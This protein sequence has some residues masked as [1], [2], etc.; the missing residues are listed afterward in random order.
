MYALFPFFVFFFFFNDTA[1]TEIYTLSL[2]DALPIYL[3]HGVDWFPATGGLLFPYRDPGQHA[4]QRARCSAVRLR[5]DEQPGEPVAGG[6]VSRPCGSLQPCRL[7]P[8]GMHTSLQPLVREMA[9]RL[10]L[11]P[12]AV[13]FHERPVLPG[14]AERWHRLAFPTQVA[15]LENGRARSGGICL[16]LAIL[17]YPLRDAPD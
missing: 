5:V 3:L 2:H 1:T 9:G 13:S 7:V 10:F 15:G 8:D 16:E 12:G 11:C 6:L 14:S 17:G 4:G